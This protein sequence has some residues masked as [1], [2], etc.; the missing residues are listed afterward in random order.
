MPD[1][2]RP[3]SDDE[4]KALQADEFRARIA[5]LR[6]P[7][8]L[9][10]ATIAPLATVFVA[11]LS[12]AWG[13]WTGFF[14]VS[15]RELEVRRRELVADML[16]LQKARDEQSA[17]FAQQKR[18]Q[19]SELET[20]RKKAERLE[21]ENR[22]MD[23]P[24]ITDAIFG[25]ATHATNFN[26]RMGDLRIEGTRFGASPGTA[27]LSYEYHYEIDGGATQ[28]KS[29]PLKAFVVSW[30]DSGIVVRPVVDKNHPL[31]SATS[32]VPP[33]SRA[34]SYDIVAIV[35]R[36]DGKVSNP[37][38]TVLEEADHLQILDQ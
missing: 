9:R 32:G 15:R 27:T 26:L 1:E 34:K 5:E 29:V 33:E 12:V 3:V 17:K 10:P 36:R 6:R 16:D 2:L 21:R 23:T 7:W 28:T 37:H 11:A 8:W 18:Q 24:V 19:E 20:L 25:S 14:D 38:K 35:H 13:M 22:Q 31:V 30:S 4:L